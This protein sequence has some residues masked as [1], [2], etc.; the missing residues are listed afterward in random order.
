VPLTVINEKFSIE[1]AVAEKA[2]LDKVLEAG[3]ENG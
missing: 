2:F 3:K 1:G